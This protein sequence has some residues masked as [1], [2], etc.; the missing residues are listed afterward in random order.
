MGGGGRGGGERA[1]RKIADLAKLKDVSKG[2]G[3][4]VESE[5]GVTNSWHG[6][7]Q[8]SPLTTEAIRGLRRVRVRESGWKAKE[9][10]QINGEGGITN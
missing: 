1:L 7:P 2:V 10:L 6:K 4:R 5:G 3:V 9:G 8:I